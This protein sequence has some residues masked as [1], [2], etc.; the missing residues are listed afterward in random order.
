MALVICFGLYL[1]KTQVCFVKISHIIF[2]WS[3]FNGVHVIDK[4]LANEQRVH[5]QS[6]GRNV[7][8]KP[9]K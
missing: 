8:L 3:V 7:H 5:S 6:D 2:E 1:I 4:P 9:L